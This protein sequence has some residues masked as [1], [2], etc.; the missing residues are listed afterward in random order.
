MPRVFLKPA[1]RMRRL[2]SHVAFLGCALALTAAGCG[3]ASTGVSEPEDESGGPVTV[4][5]LENPS[6]V[7]AFSVTDLDGKTIS[8]AELRGKIVMV[9]FW[10][11]WCGPCRAE[12]PDLVALQDKYRD[13]LVIL[14]ISEDE[15][16]VEPVR[17][18]AAKYKMNYTVAMATPEIRAAFPNVMALPTTFVLDRDG[19]LAQKS[20]GM[21]NPRETEAGMRVLAGMQTNAQIV[22]WDGKE[23]V[24]G[25]AN[26][27][28]VT[29]IP[30]LDLSSMTPERKTEALLALN[31][32]ECN[33]GCRL[34]VA[35]CRV[36]DPSCTV[37]LPQAKAIVEKLVA[38]K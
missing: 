14:G 35:R 33:C 31:E 4:R 22:R 3:D 10:A 6:D 25:L 18:F 11:T 29:G 32:E 15:T 24:L 30:G 16:G 38:K 19:R 2:S 21:L 26:A 27:A 17:Q 36:D 8:S 12:I 34:T 7:P 1:S 5:L 9:N 23:K 20:V 28:Q 37:S 13:Q